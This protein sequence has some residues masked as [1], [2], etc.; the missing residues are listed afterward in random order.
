MCCERAGFGTVCFKGAVALL[1]ASISDRWY[2]VLAL[3]SE[4]HF[5]PILLCPFTAE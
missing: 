4:S 5:W 1:G 3:K 2:L